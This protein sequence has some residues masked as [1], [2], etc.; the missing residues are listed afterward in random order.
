MLSALSVFVDLPLASGVG[1][2][3]H[4]LGF[5][6][7]LE[8]HEHRN[9]RLHR[10]A[11]MVVTLAMKTMIPLRAVGVISSIFQSAFALLAGITP[12]LIQHSV[13]LPMNAYRLYEQPQGEQ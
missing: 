1:R 11:L 5:G 8:L 6:A 9:H 4:S 7:S 13:L 10:P 2:D 12:M 3:V